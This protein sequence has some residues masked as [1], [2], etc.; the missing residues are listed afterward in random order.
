MNEITETTDSKYPEEVKE[1]TRKA[2][3]TLLKKQKYLLCRENS[4]D[5]YD[6]KVERETSLKP[7][8]FKERKPTIFVPL[9]TEGGEF[10]LSFTFFNEDEVKVLKDV[11]SPF[12]VEVKM[13]KK[14]HEEEVSKTFTKELT[15]GSDKLVFFKSVFSASTTYYLKMRIVYQG[16]N[17]QWSH[18]EQNSPVNLEEGQ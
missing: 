8:G 6:L 17:T 13:W 1:L 7:V 18:E 9:F 12:E 14:G 3:L 11:D 2:K 5:S 15:L 4:L 10:S 16:M